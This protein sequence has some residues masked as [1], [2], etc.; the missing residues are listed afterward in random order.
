MRKETNMKRYL[1]AFAAVALAASLWT[2]GPA[3]AGTVLPTLAQDLGL[4]LP[5]GSGSEGVLWVRIGCVAPASSCTEAACNSTLNSVQIKV[6]CNANRWVEEGQISWGDPYEGPLT[7]DS[8]E[9][10][11]TCIGKVNIGIMADRQLHWG[12]AQNG[13]ECLTSQPQFIKLVDAN[14]PERMFDVNEIPLYDA[15]NFQD[16]VSDDTSDNDGDGDG[17]S[18]AI[19]SCPN[20]PPGKVVMKNGCPFPHI[21]YFNKP[22]RVHQ[23]PIIKPVGPTKKAPPKGTVQYKKTRVI[24]RSDDAGDDD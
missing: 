10:T 16:M 21:K 3:H 6:Q 4:E 15:D 23:K 17:V 2:A 20:T 7:T 24:I 8:L 13:G 12:S 5:S 14:S 9:K 22:H 19:D 11:G 18:D 1:I